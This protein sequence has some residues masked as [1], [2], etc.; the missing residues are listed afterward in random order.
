MRGAFISEN[1]RKCF[2]FVKEVHKRAF[3]HTENMLKDSQFMYA[4]HSRSPREIFEYNKN[5]M[6]IFDKDHFRSH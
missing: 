1:K 4:T 2:C 6:Q 3:P 5:A